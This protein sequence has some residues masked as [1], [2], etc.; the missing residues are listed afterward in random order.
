VR[1]HPT[2]A[3]VRVLAT[4]TFNPNHLRSH[5]LPLLAVDEVEEVILVAD[6]PAP[7][8]P[9]LRTI[10]PPRLL[11]RLVGRAAA[12][13]VV[14]AVVALRTRPDWVIGFNL[15]PHGLNAFVAGRLSGAR[16][17]YHQIGGTREWEGGGWWSD[18]RFLG[19][20]RRPSPAVERLLLGAVRRADAVAAMGERGRQGLIERG[21]SPSRIAVIPAAIDERRLRAI[22]VQP[23][24]FDLVTV[25]ALL[26]NK[27]TSDFVEAVA[28]LK[29]EGRTIRAAVLGDGEL[30][31]EL[32][33][34]AADL[35]VGEEVRFLGFRE[36]VHEICAR[37]RVF[38]L[39]SAYEGLSLAL[40]DAMALGVVPVVSDVGEARSVVEDGVTG[41]TYPCG[42]IDALV[43]RARE[44]LDD[45]ATRERLGHAARER[46]YAYAG[47][48]VVASTLRGVLTGMPNGAATSS[49][50]ARRPVDEP[51]EIY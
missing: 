36:D 9:R 26:P 14:C 18:N 32:E 25:G 41:F 42:A 10:V 4:V 21:V 2:S 27:R 17:L 46:A 43:D 33:A 51:Q 28:R 6:E 37:S 24:E 40:V 7:S 13:L 3:R 20:L 35:G 15:V 19:R 11:S 44:L 34:R 47:V 48:D 49:F 16:V 23:P 30:R 5:F 45:H 29:A 39:S 22:P 8:L 12:K 38:V 1:S 31:A 50:G